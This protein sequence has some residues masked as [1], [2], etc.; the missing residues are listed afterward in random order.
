MRHNVEFTGLLG[1]SRHVR[2]SIGFIP[3]EKRMKYR[4]VKANAGHTLLSL[5]LLR[6]VSARR[7]K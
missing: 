6:I 2:K 3:M 1:Q 5:P 7:V 4:S